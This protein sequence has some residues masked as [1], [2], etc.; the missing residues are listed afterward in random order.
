MTG[1]SGVVAEQNRK[2][3]GSVLGNPSPNPFNRNISIDVRPAHREALLRIFDSSGREVADLSGRLPSDNSAAS[4]TFDAA[5]LPSGLYY[6]RYS[7]GD[8]SESRQMLLIR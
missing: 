7:A 2:G 4:I 1:T 3:S 6:I 5:S 8:Y